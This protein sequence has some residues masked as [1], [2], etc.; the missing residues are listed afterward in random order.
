MCLCLG[1]CVR[2][3]GMRCCGGLEEGE[4]EEG[5]YCWLGGGGCGEEGLDVGWVV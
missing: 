5:L 1:V 2:V 4:S 3:K